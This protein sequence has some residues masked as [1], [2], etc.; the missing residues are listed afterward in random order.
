[1]VS[2][3]AGGVSFEAVIMVPENANAVDVWVPL[4][5]LSQ[6]STVVSTKAM[7]HARYTVKPR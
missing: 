5:A 3:R 7:A 6:S 2:A 4:L 1:M